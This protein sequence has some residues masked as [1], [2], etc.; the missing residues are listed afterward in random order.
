M[1]LNKKVVLIIIFFIMIFNTKGYSA[2][3]PNVN[4]ELTE[5]QKAIIEVANAYWR[6]DSNIQY[7]SMKRNYLLS[8]EAAT[9]DDILNTTC[10][11]F[12]YQI[13]KQAFNIEIPKGCSEIFEYCKIKKNTEYVP[14]FY[15][16]EDF[17]NT[18]DDYKKESEEY[19]KLLMAFY[20]GN[21][22]NDNFYL[23]FIK[24][25]EIGDII[26]ERRRGAST[27]DHTMIVED[28][29]YDN[30]GNKTDCI[31]IESNDA[32]LLNIDDESWSG[33]GG[34][35]DKNGDKLE[36][37][38]SINKIKLSKRLKNYAKAYINSFKKPICLV[39]CRPLGNDSK[40]CYISMEDLKKHN[41]D[42]N[43]QI[44]DEYQ[45]IQLTDASKSRLKYK[46]IDIEK[47][48]S[49]HTNSIVGLGDEI[50]YTIKIRNNGPQKYEGIVIKEYI[51]SELVEC[52][53]SDKVDNNGKIELTWNNIDIDVGETKELS[54]KVRVKTD[55]KNLNK[56]IISKGYVDNIETAKIINKISVIPTIEEK[57][58]LIESSNNINYRNYENGMELI[59]DIY[60]DALGIEL[61]LKNEKGQFLKASDI[62]KTN[63]SKNIE[64]INE[65]FISNNLY[66]TWEASRKVTD[67]TRYYIWG[68]AYEE[69]GDQNAKTILKGNLNIGDIILIENEGQ[70]KAYI[71]LENKIIGAN[72]IIYETK[73]VSEKYD[74]EDAIN[75]FLADLV[76][77]DSFV[78]LS[79]ATFMKLTDT[80]LDNSNN[81]E[82]LNNLNNL[83]NSKINKTIMVLPN[84]GKSKKLVFICMN[85]LIVAIV[86]LY[87]KFKEYKDIK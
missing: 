39:V 6:K 36:Q 84:T 33:K 61:K 85:I 37:Y 66:G 67:S 35:A 43:I 68:T 16:T 54:Y 62:V 77:K 86:L 20:E 45:D 48:G 8:P 10:H 73:N 30:Q 22:V 11:A 28:F 29:I 64:L 44:N 2:N 55:I 34:I 25:L 38:G 4:K 58:K 15:S 79:P 56:N 42:N 69:I 3:I 26:T 12:A 24:K 13:Y 80:Q 72:E 70:E 71:F 75:K 52:E 19:K 40:Y 21:D 47:L 57:K 53:L 60:K 1:K 32:K 59:N 82:N 23:E 65:N 5:K 51:N 78:I 87:I 27:S 14:I 41:E 49:E 76:S 63:E 81:L 50:T 46:G 18:S 9:K 74:A 7:E 83:E 17:K 31:L